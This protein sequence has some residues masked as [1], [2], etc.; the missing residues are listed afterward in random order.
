MDQNWNI[1]YETKQWAAKQFITSEDLNKIEQGIQNADEKSLILK[2]N[3]GKNYD[4][5]KVYSVN[6]YC[7]YE[8]FLYKCISDENTTIPSTEINSGWQRIDIA[9]ELTNILSMSPTPSQEYSIWNGG[10][11]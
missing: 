1:K 9:E 4:E 10:N 5:T 3:I 8:G 2:Q 6:D 11:Y 7:I